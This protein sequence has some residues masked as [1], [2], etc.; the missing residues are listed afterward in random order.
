LLQHQLNVTAGGDADAIKI[1]GDEDEDY[2]YVDCRVHDFNIYSFAPVKS[3]VGELNVFVISIWQ[4]Y[5]H[6][7]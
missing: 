6:K 3:V 1:D 5:Y 7:R 2:L 4:V